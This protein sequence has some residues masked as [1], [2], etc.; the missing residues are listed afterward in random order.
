MMVYIS[1]SMKDYKSEYVNEIKS[2]FSEHKIIDPS[3]YADQCVDE[4]RIGGYWWNMRNV[5]YPLIRECEL[6]VAVPMENGNYS[7]GVITEAKYT[8]EMDI[9]LWCW[10]P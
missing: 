9:D 4:K 1:H 10:Q 3:E 8:R 6:V 5:F 2:F 7:T